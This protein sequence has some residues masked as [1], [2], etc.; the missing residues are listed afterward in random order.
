[1]RECIQSAEVLDV[2][3]MLVDGKG[4]G[5]GKSWDLWEVSHRG[6]RGGLSDCPRREGS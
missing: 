1:M 4:A 2:A 6:G 3:H 5:Q